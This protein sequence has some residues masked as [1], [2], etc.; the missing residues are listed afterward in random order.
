MLHISMGQNA[1]EALLEPVAK[2]RRIIDIVSNAPP[3]K[4]ED[5]LMV[6]PL[7]PPDFGGRLAEM[8]WGVRKVYSP[9]IEYLL[10]AFPS[11]SRT[12]QLKEFGVRREITPELH[13][14]LRCSRTIRLG[15]IT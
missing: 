9:P 11:E 3:L 4:L 1:E 14:I 8:L 12:E 15:T 7:G 2:R 13:A 5:L 10:P 6:H